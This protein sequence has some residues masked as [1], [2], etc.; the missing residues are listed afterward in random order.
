MNILDFTDNII[1][2]ILS[3][4]DNKY[5]LNLTCKRFYETSLGKLK[6]N[7]RGWMGYRLTYPMI[8]KIFEYS[9]RINCINL[10]EKLLS[11]M[12]H[13]TDYN[14]NR[15]HQDTINYCIVYNR[16]NL[17]KIL[18]RYGLDPSHPKSIYFIKSCKLGRLE[19]VK[20]LSKEQRININER[21]E[22]SCSSLVLAA[23]YG[24]L[25][26]VK[27]LTKLKNYDLYDGLEYA[28]YIAKLNK[29]FNVVD[30]LSTFMSYSP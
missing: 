5:N 20:Y 12:I 19:I 4:S 14:L 27:Y 10:F 18:I 29:H 6:K 26:V 9:I 3:F 24:H 17:L 25:N 16:L 11:D 21:N 22:I 8:R 28:V 23:E 13:F 2:H 15:F 7:R 1:I 30:Y